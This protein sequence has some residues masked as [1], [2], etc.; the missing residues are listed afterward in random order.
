MWD[1]WWTEWDWDKFFSESF[2]F[3]LSISIHHCPISLV[4]SEGWIMGLLVAA[5]P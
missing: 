5:V 1:L 2:G 4:P 3:H